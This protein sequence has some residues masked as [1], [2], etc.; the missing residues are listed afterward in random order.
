MRYLGRLL[1]LPAL[2][3]LFSAASAVTAAPVS[4][5]YGWSTDTT[6]IAADPGGAGTISLTPN[7]GGTTAGPGSIAALSFTTLTAATDAAPDHFTG[8]TYGLTLSLTDNTTH[9]S[10]A[11]NFLGSVNG[12]L[13][14]ANDKLFLGYD[15]LTGVLDL[16]GDQFD[17]TL[18]LPPQPGLG[19]VS[20]QVNI[21]EATGGNTGGPPPGPTPGPQP[22]PRPVPHDSPEPSA[23]VLAA[24]GLV[25]LGVQAWRRRAAAG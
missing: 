4:W 9:A 17:V 15:H 18:A 16:G 8:D 11:L 23:L 1:C 7:P 22:G 14:A 21:Q 13:S 5:T 10:G 6:T 3:F 12:T 24:L 19:I 20:A 2:A 25:G